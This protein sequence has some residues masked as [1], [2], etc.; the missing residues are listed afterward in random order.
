MACAFPVV[1][2]VSYRALR[3]PVPLGFVHEEPGLGEAHAYLTYPA[4]PHH[5]LA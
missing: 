1:V 5:G 3:G 2:E 4:A